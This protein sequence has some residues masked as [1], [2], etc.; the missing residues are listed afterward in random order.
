MDSSGL[1]VRRLDCEGLSDH[2]PATS[3]SPQPAGYSAS[4]AASLLSVVC[5]QAGLR[6]LKPGPVDCSVFPASS[7]PESNLPLGRA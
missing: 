1:T 5:C 2:G 6:A 3:P 7:L 4:G